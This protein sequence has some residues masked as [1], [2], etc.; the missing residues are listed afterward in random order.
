MTW[1]TYNH[2]SGGRSA[3]SEPRNAAGS[4]LA[5]LSAPINQPHSVGQTR[6]WT[7]RVTRLGGD[8]GLPDEAAGAAMAGAGHRRIAAALGVPHGTTQSYL[9]VC[10]SRHLIIAYRKAMNL[11]GAA[12]GTQ[13]RRRTWHDH[14]FQHAIHRSDWISKS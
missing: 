10:L 11:G 13:V 1:P 5:R 8:E 9:P 12:T 7:C 2:F 14:R 3:A 6:L 4:A